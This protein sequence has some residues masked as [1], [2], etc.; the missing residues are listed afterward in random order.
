MGSNLLALVGKEHPL[1][2]LLLLRSEGPR[3]FSEV[4]EATGLNPSQ[5]DRALKLL[6]EGM[7]VIPETIPEEEGPVHVRYRLT[8][9]GLA[10][11][12]AVDAFRTGLERHRSAIGEDAV[13]ELESLYA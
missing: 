13:G 2:I 1:R 5:V 3:R 10:F 9:R 11:L 6:R 7:W 8:D 12:K 4:E